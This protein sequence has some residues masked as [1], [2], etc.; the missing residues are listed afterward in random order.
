MEASGTYGKPT[1]P[2]HNEAGQA[3]ALY[4][5]NA[6]EATPGILSKPSMRTFGAPAA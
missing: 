6:V 2:D 1:R 3:V 5:K 4:L